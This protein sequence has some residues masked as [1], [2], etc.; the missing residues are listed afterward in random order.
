MYGH[1]GHVGFGAWLLLIIGAILR[2]IQWLRAH[3]SP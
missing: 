2:G 1:N 3:F